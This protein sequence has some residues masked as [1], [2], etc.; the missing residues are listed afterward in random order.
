MKPELIS[1]KCTRCGETRILSFEKKQRFPLAWAG[2]FV[3]TPC[4]NKAKDDK[5]N[6]LKA[7]EMLRKEAVVTDSLDYGDL[8][9]NLAVNEDAFYDAMLD[10]AVKFNMKVNKP[11]KFIYYSEKKKEF[12]DEL[13]S[14]TTTIIDKTHA[15][16]FQVQPWD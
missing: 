4:R 1:I 3:C 2:G 7:L 15:W 6:A 10:L 13:I 16:A 14:A 12:I 11:S 9:K 5:Q 8:C